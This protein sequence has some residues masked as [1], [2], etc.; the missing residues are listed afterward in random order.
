MGAEEF[1]RRVRLLIHRTGCDRQRAVR[2]M[3]QALAK[4]EREALG[5]RAEKP[6]KPATPTER[7]APYP[8][9]PEASVAEHEPILSPP[10]IIEP[11]R[12]ALQTAPSPEAY[13]AEFKPIMSPPVI[14]DPVTPT[15]P[16]ASR[17]PGEADAQATG[18]QIETARA[19]EGEEW[20][21]VQ[22]DLDL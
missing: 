7:P 19:A 12:S 14:V 11:D 1:E 9:A 3:E 10:V 21:V 22:D 13:V 8:P 4:R 18:A 2:M 15:R 6:K 20:V 5:S 17:L 16:V